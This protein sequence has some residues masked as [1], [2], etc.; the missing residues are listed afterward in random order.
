MGLCKYWNG[1]CYAGEEYLFLTYFYPFS[2]RILYSPR[3]IIYRNVLSIDEYSSYF[4]GIDPLAT[5]KTWTAR[6]IGNHI[7]A[8]RGD[9]V[10]KR[11]QA[12][13]VLSDPVDWSRDI[14]VW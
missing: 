9:V 11:V 4:D 6:E 12:A 7:K 13:F 2:P 1:S 8:E 10:S 5:Y 14:Q 3:N